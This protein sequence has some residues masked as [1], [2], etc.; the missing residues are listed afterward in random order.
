MRLALFDL[1]HTL[2]PYD[3]GM[4]WLRFLV[5]QGR[6]PAEVEA[7]Y[8]E[9]CLGYV[10]GTVDVHA[11]HR[12]LVLPLRE[13]GRATLDAWLAE[14][15][16]GL[17]PTLPPAARALVDGHRAAGDRCCLVT[18]TTRCVAERYA[19]AFGIGEVIATEALA[20]SHGR[21]TG[22]IAGPPCVGAHKL[23]KLEG[24]LRLEGLTLAS[25]EA[26]WFYSDAYGDLPLLQTVSAPVAVR[27]DP[28]L[29]EHAE[30]AGW[31]IEMLGTPGA[32]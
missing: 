5:D 32:P 28:R 22:E 11:L 29:R 15:E 26:S 24:W 23:A 19:A 1:D 21:L 27:P 31:P 20:D 6:L 8:L 2:I 13:V 4:A 25:F 9:H 3:S 30:R 7:R 18:A 17:A 14:F 16:A 10:G 12:A